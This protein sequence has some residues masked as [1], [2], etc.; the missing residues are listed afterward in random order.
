LFRNLQKADTTVNELL[1]KACPVCDLNLIIPEEVTETIMDPNLE[2]IGVEV[3]DR[4][5]GELLPTLT[6]LVHSQRPVS[7]AVLG[8]V[9]VFG[10]AANQLLKAARAETVGQS[11]ART[12]LTTSGLSGSVAE[13]YLEAIRQGELLLWVPQPRGCN[14]TSSPTPG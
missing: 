6:Q 2:P 9:F 5:S 8:R 4:A 14:Q 13:R 10:L 12:L 11:E 1:T 3:Y 7:S